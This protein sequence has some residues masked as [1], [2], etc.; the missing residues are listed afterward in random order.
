MSTAVLQPG[1]R[2]GPRKR[3]P[4]MIDRVPERE[5]DA[6]KWLAKPPKA[7]AVELVKLAR[8]IDATPKA[9]RRPLSVAWEW[10]GSKAIG[11]SGMWRE[12]AREPYVSPSRRA[13]IEART[14][15]ARRWQV[16]E[17]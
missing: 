9:K 11:L 12:T 7:W 14:A 10:R 15:A 16:L 4:L 6:A 5:I 17:R 13:L 2:G 3:Q 8:A 1:P